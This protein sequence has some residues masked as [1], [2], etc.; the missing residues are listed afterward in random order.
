TDGTAIVYTRIG[1]G[2]EL[3]ICHGSLSTGHEWLPVAGHLAD[4]FTCYVMT[5]RGR[6]HS[7]R[8]DNYALQR[9][10]EDLAALLEHV[11]GHAHLLGHSYGALCALETARQSSAI[12]HLLLYEPPL[13]VAPLQVT[14]EL[15]NYRQA[16]AEGRLEDALLTGFRTFVG[17]PD[18]ELAALRKMLLW[19]GTVQLAPSWLPELEAIAALP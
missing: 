6:G 17:M 8:G 1:S 19:P 14:A 7:G 3:I 11:G 2:P 13:P 16:I 5:R 15:A 4:R 10:C 9:E 12:D 18:S